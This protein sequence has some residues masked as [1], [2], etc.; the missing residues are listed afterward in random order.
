MLNA[1]KSFDAYPKT[2]D[3]FRE[4]WVPGAAISI[5]STCVILFIVLGEISMYTNKVYKHSL[6][7]DTEVTGSIEVHLDITFNKL[8]C[9]VMNV[10]AVDIF[11]EPTL[12]LERS[13]TKTRLNEKGE[14]VHSEA[15]NVDAKGHAA[16][17]S[18]DVQ[19]I[20]ATKVENYCGSCYGAEAQKAQCC[21]TC[22]E[23]KEAY[24]QRG[25]QFNLF[26]TIEQCARERLQKKLQ[27]T[28]HEGCSIKGTVRVNKVQGAL[29]F[30]PGKSLLRD[31]HLTLSDLLA[32]RTE[33]RFDVSHTINS[34]SFGK[35][36]PG[37][38]NP[39]DG[40]SH[41]S[42]EP[43]LFQFRIKVVPTKFTYLSGTIVETNQYSVTEHFTKSTGEN[44]DGVYLNYD[45]SPI[46]VDITESLQ[47]RSLLHFITSLCAAVG[48]VFTV[49]GLVDSLLYH[50]HK[51]LSGKMD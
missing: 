11:G 2:L 44:F 27:A 21:N 36:F 20:E 41:V 1:F 23:V 31:G 45:L 34:L 9:A 43:G 5:V 50:G 12:S 28:A 35:V 16:E 13:I 49:A 8:P 6:Y 14:E 26:D 38:V 32:S 42:E 17:H 47:H 24:Y 30:A 18:S 46:K 10:D 37:L 29:H 39:L 15:E 33:P 7:V 40:R 51:K 48:G 25:W 3:D 22:N 19:H 4:R